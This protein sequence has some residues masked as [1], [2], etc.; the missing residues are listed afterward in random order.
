MATR[1]RRS[2]KAASD[3][4]DVWMSVA[5]KAMSHPVRV[6]ILRALAVD[7]HLSPSG[8]ADVVSATLATCAYHMREL[9][10]LG[11]VRLSKTRPARG[12]VEHFY[13]LTR[14]GEAVVQAMNS[15]SA[16]AP[17]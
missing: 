11:L 1:S 3:S 13:V 8:V 4:T 10:E 5:G 15:V 6:R 12:A 16:L 14:D 17:R 9:A 2:G 7:G